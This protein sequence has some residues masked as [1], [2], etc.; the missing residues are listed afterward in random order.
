MVLQHRVRS[1]NIRLSKSALDDKENAPQPKIEKWNYGSS[2]KATLSSRS[3]EFTKPLQEL[4]Q[5]S[6][7]LNSQCT[8]A[9]SR[10]DG[11]SYRESNGVNLLKAPTTQY[12]QPQP[13][14]SVPPVKK[15][16]PSLKRLTLRQVT[17]PRSYLSHL[18]DSS[19]HFPNTAVDQHR[20]ADKPEQSSSTNV[21]G[22]ATTAATSNIIPANLP[23]NRISTISSSQNLQS[24]KDHA[25][26]TIQSRLGRML[27]LTPKTNAAAAATTNKAIPAKPIPTENSFAV[28]TLGSIRPVRL[29]T[30]QSD[31]DDWLRPSSKTTAADT[32]TSNTISGF[33]IPSNISLPEVTLQAPIQ[34]S[35]PITTKAHQRY[36]PEHLFKSAATTDGMPVITSTTQNL[37]QK[38]VPVTRDRFGNELGHTFETTK[39]A[40]TNNNTSHTKSVLMEGSSAIPDSR[41]L[42]PNCTQVAAQSRQRSRLNL[43]PKT[44]VGNVATTKI[45]PPRPVPVENPPAIPTLRNTQETSG[46]NRT[47]TC[48]E[49]DSESS[50]TMKIAATARNDI[51]GKPVSYKK[52]STITTKQDSKSYCASDIPQNQQGIGLEQSRSNTAGITTSNVIP[53]YYISNERDPTI[54]LSANP[55]LRHITLTPR[56]RDAHGLVY[57]TLSYVDSILL[58]LKESEAIKK[59]NEEEIRNSKERAIVA[60]DQSRPQ[61]DLHTKQEKESMVRRQGVD[62]DVHTSVEDNQLNYDSMPDPALVGEYSA[63]IFDYLRQL[64]IELHPK[65]ANFEKIADKMWNIRQD[66]INLLISTCTHYQARSETLYLAVH[67]FD[68]VVSKGFILTKRGVVLGLTC[69]VLAWKFEERFALELMY[70]LGDMVDQYDR[71]TISGVKVIQMTEIEVLKL[72]EFELGWP[73]PM[74]F[75]R[76]CSRA[77]GSD[78]NTRQIAKYLMEQI[79]SHPRFLLYKPS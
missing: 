34:T 71:Q 64:E 60:S 73:G 78:Y 26:V 46:P 67:L 55:E 50:S 23:T 49:N 63:E 28:P 44:V 42:D 54:S 10:L 77:D 20:L 19:K 79:L 69:L 12:T 40:A 33:P 70:R 58:K 13:K 48:L 6:S 21:S 41:S 3:R 32:T 52:I 27:E 25:S 8:P 47:R 4:K 1:S 16:N 22:T 14:V 72:V 7:A 35:A 51:L 59:N 31:L 61:A 43:V 24:N 62:N 66:N 76:R 2:S 39:I 18:R 17:L 5:T 53:T 57:P 74:P 11:H 75:L 37:E 9:N 30:T 29:V 38:Y 68:R 65:I 45:I 15:T 36:N 56:K